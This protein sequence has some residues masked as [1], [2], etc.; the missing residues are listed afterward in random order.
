VVGTAAVGGAAGAAATGWST[1]A[2]VGAPVEAVAPGGDG[3]T[4]PVGV[5]GTAAEVALLVVVVDVPATG[6][7]PGVDTALVGTGVTSGPVAEVC[8]TPALRPVTGAFARALLEA[9]DGVA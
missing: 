6:A 4:E 8:T 3:G 5:A 7:P 2:I 1:G 9:G